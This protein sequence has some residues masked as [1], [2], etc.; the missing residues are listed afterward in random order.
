M[1]Q[2]L[3]AQLQ[4]CLGVDQVITDPATQ[5]GYLADWRGRYHGRALAV[6]LPQS[7]AQV[8][9]VVRLCVAANTPI[10]PQGGNTGLC[11]GATP[12]TSG[13]A[14]VVAMT[15]INRIRDVDARNF[16]ITAEAG[17][18]LDDLKAAADS[19]D[20]LYPLTL[21]AGHRSTLGGTLAT[22]A[23]GLQVLRY[24]M[25]RDLCLGL[26]VVLPDG[27]IW[28]K[29]GG[30]RKDNTGFDL[31]QW[32]IG[33]EGTL[34]L[35]TA[36]T[37]KLYPQASARALVW[38]DLPD[39]DSAVRAHER[40]QSVFAGSQT[41]AELIS[42]PTLAL[43]R[44]HLPEAALPAGVH[45]PPSPNHWALM[46]EVA[47]HDAAFLESLLDGWQRAS[48][49]QGCASGVIVTDTDG[50][51]ALWTIRKGLAEAQ[52][53]EG[54]SIKHDISLPISHIPAFVNDASAALEQ[55]FPGIRIIVFGHIGDGNLHYNL[56]YADAAQ[57]AVLLAQSD[58]AHQIV[59]EVVTRLGGSIA[60]EHGIGQL[61]TGWLEQHAPA[62]S[63][64][65]MRKLK[66]VLDPKGLMNPGK[67]LADRH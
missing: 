9:E 14:V 48:A 12:D 31:K 35:I 39:T 4:D 57:N 13:R 17:A 52:K 54:I 41:A 18:T 43:V 11:G 36:A 65:L 60:A 15:R 20:R 40:A 16:S 5:A 67:V 21:G 38:L 30:L 34:G 6:V 55:R 37:M 64:D 25:T 63:L 62:G 45:W 28:S 53:R 8:A 22:N 58:D 44:H 47:A 26:E 42:A 10:V 7:T 49:A 51:Q 61:K 27:T 32:F 56:S 3:I 59:Y 50:Q 1:C 33:A 2:T 23:G 24:G 66:D 46:I 19:V 29:L